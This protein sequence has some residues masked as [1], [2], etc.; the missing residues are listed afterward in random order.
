MF[1]SKTTQIRIIIDGKHNGL[2]SEEVF[3][4]A[5]KRFGQ[6]PRVKKE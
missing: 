1:P 6:N 2:I 3:N 4:A 5:Q